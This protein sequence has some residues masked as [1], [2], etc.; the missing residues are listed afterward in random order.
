M[1]ANEAESE[2]RAIATFAVMA[3]LM[4]MTLSAGVRAESPVALTVR[5]YNTSGI[6]TPEL[7]AARRAAE[8]ILR[9][10]GLGR[11]LPALRARRLTGR[12]DRSV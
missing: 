10:I 9:D 2:M 7:V 12:P 3:G 5:L 8:S 1:P 6:P 4:A 11:G